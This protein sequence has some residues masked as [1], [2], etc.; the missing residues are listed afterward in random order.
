MSNLYAIV[1]IETTGSFSSTGGITEIAIVVT[2]GQQIIE[3]YETLVNP[4]AYIPPFIQ[5]LTGISN[6]MVE[7][8][9]Q[10]AEVAKEIAELL[11]GKIFVAHNVNF[12][13]K[14]VKY[15]LELAG[16]SIGQPR[17]CTVRLG[18]KILP[19][20][21]SYSLGKLTK[22][23]GIKHESKHRAMSDTMATTE[24]F[25]LLIEKGEGDILATLKTVSKQPNLPA[26]LPERI[27]NK[28]P[29]ETGIYYFYNSRKEIIYIGKAKNI[30]KRVTTHFT[31]KAT[32]Q[33]LSF[34]KE[35]YHVSTELTGTELIASLLEDAEIKH[36]WPIYNRS[37]KSKVNKFGVFLYE[38]QKGIA[39]L[40]ITKIGNQVKPLKTFPSLSDTRNWLIKKIEEFEL[41]PQLCGM[42]E[43]D[44]L[45]IE[46]EEHQENIQKFL[47]EYDNASSSFLLAGKGRAAGEQS[48]VLVEKGTY[49]GYGFLNRE[50]VSIST[51]EEVEN[52]LIRR[53]ET[54]TTRT[55]IRSEKFNEPIKKIVF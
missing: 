29:Q 31:G 1:D 7:N 36:Y 53:E 46:Q 30:K 47:D 19:G 13:Y 45:V 3:T 54:I 4:N 42:P 24:L 35:V 37:Q 17:L 41:K 2:D 8:A 49:K 9:P 5:N 51:I 39:Q 43:F 55:I 48:F 34:Y 28:L 15:E 44:S 40:G 12:D 16:Y 25:H 50:E 52:Y 18:R 20:L 22:T 21:P 6:E 11:E 27:F 10:F 32:A 26:N 14:Y 33:K 38:N 23:L